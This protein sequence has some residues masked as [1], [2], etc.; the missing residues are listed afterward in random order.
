MDTNLQQNDNYWKKVVVV[1]C[2]G[3]VAIWIY[4]TI[5]NP[6]LPLL[7]TE[8]GIDSDATIG[9]ISTMY[10]LGYTAMQIPSGILADKVGR[11]KIMVPGFILFALAPILIGVS[12]SFTLILV[13]SLLAGIFSGSYYGTA[14]ATSSATI[15]EKNRGFATAIINSGSAIGMTIGMLG[16]SWFVLQMGFSWRILAFISAAIILVM[17]IVFALVLKEKPKSE[18]KKEEAKT[19]DAGTSGTADEKVSFKF[20]VSD[21]RVVSAYLL[22][23]ATCYAYYMIVTWLPAFLQQERGFEGSAI[24]LASSMVAIAGIPGAL[25]F[26]KFSD[27]YA[28]KK[29]SQIIWLQ[30]SVVFVV[31]LIV[32]LTQN[33]LVVTMLILYGLLG[34]LAVEPIMISHMSTIA[35]KKGYSTFFGFFNFFGMSS[36]VVAPF[37]TGLIADAT[38]SR[39]IAFYVAAVI[40]IIA[41]IFFAIANRRGKATAA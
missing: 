41:I 6:L 40:L 10:F 8:F 36:S 22:Y 37:L 25:I 19:P 21:K 24:G 38:G 29:I 17:A 13:A 31:F 3:W 1:L 32:T 15:P 5:L 35:P 27:K 28:D 26:S 7:Q 39:V 14:Y 20:L 12:T 18:E 2:L 4:R 9:L 30:I 33:W 34:K 11:K 16:S 23:F